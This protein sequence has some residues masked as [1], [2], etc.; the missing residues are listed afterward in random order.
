MPNTFLKKTFDE[1]M[2]LVG[3]DDNIKSDLT[4]T[5][6]VDSLS[7]V[8]QR[9]KLYKKTPDRGLVIFCGALPREGGGPPG[10]EIV[11]VFE[12]DPIYGLVSVIV[13]LK[14]GNQDYTVVDRDKRYLGIL[15]LEIKN[16]YPQF[17]SYIKFIDGE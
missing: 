13:A 12:I 14:S 5:H 1:S 11:K 8:V 2:K 3:S 7:K 9:L 10:S 17:S 16:K 4:R 6:V 15:A